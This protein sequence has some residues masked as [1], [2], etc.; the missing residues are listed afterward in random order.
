MGNNLSG[1][2]PTT[3]A[4][5]I[6]TYIEELEGLSYKK[7]LGN[8]RFIKTVK[9]GSKNGAVVIKIMV[10]P[11]DDKYQFQKHVIELKE[12]YDK[13][14]NINNVFP[15]QWQLETF[16]AVYVVRQ[17]FYYSLYDRIS[18]RPFLNLIEKKLITFHLL[19]GLSEAHER[20]V[21][22]GDIKI[23]NI[24][25]TS[26]N[27]AFLSDFAPFK[28]VYLPLDNPSDFLFFFDPLGK[29]S[30][31]IAPERFYKP[32]NK[33][34]S[35][36]LTS[37]MDIFSL[38]CVIAE[39][40]TESTPLFL[41]SQLLSYKRGDYDPSHT[42]NQ[43]EC[44]EIR[45]MVE[46]MIQL[47]P[48]K[49][50]SAR[51]Y[52]I[53]WKDKAFPSYFYDFLHPY[54]CSIVDPYPNHELDNIELQ[55]DFRI[56]KLYSDYNQISAIFDFSNDIDNPEVNLK[57]EEGA[58]LLL[59]VLTSSVKNCVY[60]SKKR[61]AIDMMFSIGRHLNDE[62]KLDRLLPYLVSLLY[63]KDSII[64]SHAI[65]TM[66][67]LLLTVHKI[68][69]I[70]TLL[71]TEYLF[72]PLKKLT[73]DKE[74]IVRYSLAKN[75]ASL[76]EIAIHFY[77]LGKSMENKT[78]LDI[79][80]LDL[81]NP[82]LDLVITLLIDSDSSVKR[83]LLSNILRLCKV[84]GLQKSNDSLLSHMITY[85]NDK[86]WLLRCSFFENIV[87][88]GQYV[89]GR[90]LEEYIL[91]LMIQAITDSEEF[92]VEKVLTS[93]TLLCQRKLFS[94]ITL[95]DLIHI[96]SPLLGHPNVWIRYAA[97]AFTSTASELLPDVDKLCVL[98]PTIQ[99]FIKYPPLLEHSVIELSQA[100]AEPITR[101]IYEEMLSLSMAT[102]GV[103]KIIE[104]VGLNNF[105]LEKYPIR[106]QQ[107]Y[108]QLIKKFHLTN[109]NF[110]MLSAMKEYFLKLASQFDSSRM[111]PRSFSNNNYWYN[112]ST[113]HLMSLQVK[114]RTDFFSPL[115]QQEYNNNNN[116]NNRLFN[117]RNNKTMSLI[118][119]SK[120]MLRLNENELNLREG[121]LTN[122]PTFQNKV[123]PSLS[124]SSTL[125]FARTLQMDTY[126]NFN[127]PIISINL[128]EI[129][130]K[131][132][133]HEHENETLI[134]P[135]L[136][137]QRLLQKKGKEMFP[138]NQSIFGPVIQPINNNCNQSINTNQDWEPEGVVVANLNEHTAA[139]NSL[140]AS[141]DHKLFV[142]GSDDGAIKIWDINRIHQ[143]ISNRSRLTYFY[144]GGRVKCLTFLNNSYCVAA[145]NDKGDVHILKI[146]VI[147][148]KEKKGE[149]ET[150]KYSKCYGILGIK[151][152][153]NERVVCMQHI[154]G[155]DMKQNV[156]IMA[157][158]LSH[159]FGFD[160]N[161]NKVIYKLKI[162]LNHGNITS[163]LINPSNNWLL[164]GSD[165]GMIDLFDLRYLI[166]LKNESF[167]HP[168]KLSIKKLI[169]YK[170]QQIWILAGKNNDIS[171]WDI[172]NQECKMVIMACS[173]SVHQLSE[174]GLKP[175]KME[176][177]EEL[178]L[179][180][181][182]K[183][184]LANAV[185]FNQQLNYQILTSYL[186][187]LNKLIISGN[188]KK[189]RLIDFN[190]IE[191]SK[192]IF[193]KAINWEYKLIQHDNV[194]IIYEA[195]I[196]Y[197]KVDTK[198]ILLGHN[199]NT[200]FSHLDAILN[201]L[202]IK[203]PKHYLI[204]ADRQGTIKLFL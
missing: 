174:I 57:R 63:D 107:T 151:L 12:Q 94:K 37:E 147:F 180:S 69:P 17:Y 46:S 109:F 3:N 119:D 111:K 123:N 114:V 144:L 83:A 112:E 179:N 1:R 24:L 133:P 41:L 192:P 58:L 93:L 7:S 101:K 36:K 80:L 171:L 38:G 201:L 121:T 5:G 188:D 115:E 31:S 22:H 14:K 68:T 73:Q 32:N 98:N 176:D 13:L 139:I 89:G 99:P 16:K 136:G 153:N 100:L 8:A 155:I 106:D 91:P 127:F 51:E 168:S 150:G 169:Y 47:E 164:V 26:W 77:Q 189:I 178:L 29:R 25:L 186:V 108:Q 86:D 18:T 20:E 170:N 138:P 183:L 103:W 53:I 75:M 120:E 54:L 193:P 23:E 104:S 128:N 197:Q 172:S 28:P 159:I 195:N 64:R 48:E 143:K 158:N 137:L 185:N 49:R 122:S 194:D 56:F 50:L 173:P 11:T 52:L 67:N 97:I 190:L 181:V 160:L 165:K 146:E 70:N 81:H 82:L 156:L 134:L 95:W 40:F 62:M 79:N 72:N 129:N 126:D 110:Q 74:I 163:I 113:I 4:A 199:H 182:N 33:I 175:N 184:K 130:L 132:N 15:Y 161:L 61:L 140:Q 45:N 135:N 152:K 21:Y 198:N 76:A 157:T 60:S 196:K 166:Y 88:V 204:S 131:L 200:I 85:L 71:F 118:S 92:V 162:P 30:C 39:L 105:N 10:K 154:G 84:F 35:N 65:Q 177:D 124:T 116:N 44:P 9:G 149:L 2:I 142:T 42:I 78:S 34:T 90:S 55:T 117:K 145:A 203:Y 66:T 187:N 27:F 167:N 191:K 43:I 87:E 125:V 59:S 148:N 96:I 19:K 141:P 102:P 6:D 202:V